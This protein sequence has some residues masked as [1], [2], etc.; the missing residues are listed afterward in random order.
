MSKK[1]KIYQ[2]I[3]LKNTK[4]LYQ[5]IFRMTGDRDDTEDILHEVFIVMLFK[6]DQF[7]ADYPDNAR[8]VTAFLFG[9]AKKQLLHYWRDNH[10]IWDM[11]VSMELVPDLSDPRDGFR[12]C[13]LTLPHW[14]TPMDK[15]LLL[16]RGEGYSL[17]EIR[18][19]LGISYG[20][21]RMR[22]SRLNRELKKFFENQK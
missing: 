14:L 22:S 5:Y 18:L 12:D 13:E 21:C 16:L 3:Y 10:K 9:I 6:L 7:L 11:E 1:E 8:Q 19:Q 15:K 2:E 17:N 4:A 20:A